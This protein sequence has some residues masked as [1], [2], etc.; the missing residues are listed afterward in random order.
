M[1]S[2]SFDKVVGEDHLLG[3]TPEDVEEGKAWI[4]GVVNGLEADEVS[5][6]DWCRFSVVT[7]LGCLFNAACL[8]ERSALNLAANTTYY[9]NEQVSYGHERQAI[10]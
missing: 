10:P 1:D 8:G 7:K 3:R 5:P 2:G 4:A 9:N 6:Q